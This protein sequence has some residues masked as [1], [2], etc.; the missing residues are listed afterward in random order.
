MEKEGK[1]GWRNKSL[2]NL[3]RR[4]AA[5]TGI[6]RALLVRCPNLLTVPLGL[7]GLTVF[8]ER[9]GKLKARRKKATTVYA[10]VTPMETKEL[11][12]LPVIKVDP[13]EMAWEEM[14]AIL[15]APSTSR[16]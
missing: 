1:S 2:N 13:E 9:Q 12:V 5:S 14:P 10:L 8:R 7:P 15:E 3:F 11:Q 6:T 4:C 16:Y